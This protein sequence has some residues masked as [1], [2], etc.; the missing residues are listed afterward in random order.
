[1]SLRGARNRSENSLL[2]KVVE[3]IKIYIRFTT[4]PNENAPGTFA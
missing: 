2:P 4:S 3:I 1:M